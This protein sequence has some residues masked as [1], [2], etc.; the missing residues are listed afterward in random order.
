MIMA[1]DDLSSRFFFYNFENLTKWNW[2][3]YEKFHKS[4]KAFKLEFK[5][6]LVNFKAKREPSN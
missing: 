4:K 3:I 6:N 2:K 5:W 1:S